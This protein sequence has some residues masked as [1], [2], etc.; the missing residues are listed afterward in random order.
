[1]TLANDAVDLGGSG[2]LDM[3]I[4]N[5]GEAEDDAQWQ[6]YQASANWEL[7]HQA[8]ERTVNV[9]F[10]DGAMPPNVSDVCSTTITMVGSVPRIAA[11]T[12]GAGSVGD[13]VV[14]DGAGF[15]KSRTREDRVLFNDIAA[16]LVS[17]SD[18]RITCTVPYGTCTGV[19]TVF[20]DVGSVSSEFHVMPLVERIVPD[21]GYNTGPIHIDNLEGTG[22][23]AGGA[24][25]DVKLT[26]GPADISAKSAVVVSPQSITCDFDIKGAVVGYYS[27]VVTNEDGHSHVL[28]G[29]L[30]VDSP[31]PTLSGITPD[32]GKSAGTVDVTDMS[33][34]N[35]LDGMRA[36]LIKGAAEIEAG[37]VVVS[38][39][40]RATC[41]LDI[42]GAKAGKW[43]LRVR[44]K[45][46]KEGTLPRGFTVK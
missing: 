9:R 22:F 23:F 16:D 18:N 39:P 14:I 41:T 40:T 3:K 31:P 11:V 44:N 19:V 12:P 42:T 20:T 2:L 33:G 37:N 43:R 5:D 27:V 30:V 15:G 28:Q 36:W 7:Q 25:P 21:Y 1:V 38:S 35:F 26:N 4:W 17:W 10:R 13:P 32:S 24:A 34:D 29:G 8:G 45:D 46:G 6:R